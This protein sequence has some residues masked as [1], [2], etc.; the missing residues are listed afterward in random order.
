VQYADDSVLLVKEGSVVQGIV[1]TVTVIGK[2]F[3][4][5]MDMEKLM[6]NESKS[7]QLQ[8]RTW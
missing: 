4:I 6:Y 1:N 8:H 3:E 2:C 7:N 5:E